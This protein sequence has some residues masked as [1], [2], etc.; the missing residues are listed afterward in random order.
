VM[1]RPTV[2]VKEWREGVKGVDSSFGK[3]AKGEGGR[4]EERGREEEA[5]RSEVV[6][7]GEDDRK[8]GPVD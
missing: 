5:F 1:K 8:R 6:I 3:L 2:D 7:K 4:G